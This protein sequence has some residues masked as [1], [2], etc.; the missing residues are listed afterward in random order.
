MNQAVVPGRMLLFVTPA[1]DC[2]Y[3]P[4]RDATTVF[5]DPS[6][7]KDAWLYSSL[8]KSGF[9]RSGEHL[10][11]PECGE[12]QACV[13]VRVPVDDFRPRRSQRRVWR[14]NRDL[15]VAVRNNSFRDEHFE[16]YS[17]YLAS[18]HRSGGMDNPTPR[19]YRDFLTSP[20]ADTAFYEFRLHGR[21][22]AV[23]VADQL[24]DGLSAVYSFFDP[25]LPERSLGVFCVLWEI[26]HTKR[27]GLHWLY[28]GYWIAEAPKM[29]YKQEYLP[30]E[31]F[32]G[33]RW[34]RHTE[35]G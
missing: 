23:A 16:L 30:Q 33:G 27:L 13:P 6:H 14:T 19:Q 31:R 21:L 35:Y 2:S 15:K 1:H 34:T 7:P 3:L 24:V 4:D 11:R 10:Y 17:R 18:R 9:R 20:W 5:V 29:R 22:L 28:L 26:E 25:D 12:C 8:S 32:V